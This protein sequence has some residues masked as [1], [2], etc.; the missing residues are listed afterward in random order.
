MQCNDHFISVQLTSELQELESARTEVVTSA[1]A[2]IEREQGRVAAQVAD[3]AEINQMHCACTADALRM[4]CGCMCNAMT[5][6]GA[7][8]RGGEKDCCRGK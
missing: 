4:H 8:V 2:R 3:A 1:K 5:G 6:G 7:G